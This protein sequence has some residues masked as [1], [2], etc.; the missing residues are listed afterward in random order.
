M[1]TTSQAEQNA[2]YWTGVVVEYEDGT[3]FVMPD[4]DPDASLVFFVDPDIDKSDWLGPGRPEC[5]AAGSV[6][7]GSFRADRCG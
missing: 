5:W 6:S 3:G 2:K 1:S 4:D 7:P